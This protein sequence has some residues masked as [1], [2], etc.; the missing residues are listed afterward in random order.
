MP[1]KN[2]NTKQ[3]IYCGLSAAT[4][5]LLAVLSDITQKQDASAVEQLKSALRGIL[6]VQTYG[7]AVALVLILLAVA[8]SFIFSADSNKKAFYLGASILAIMVTAVP[9]DAKPNLDTIPNPSAA[10]AANDLGWWDRLLIPSP[11]LAQNAPP[12]TQSSP[13]TVQIE[14]ADKKL[15]SLAIFTLIDPSNGQVKRS[16]VQGSSLRFYVQNRPY[17][18]RVQVDGYTIAESSINPPLPPPQTLSITLF[19]SRVPLSIQRLLL[20]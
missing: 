14:T 13:V 3:T 10:G 6:G 17:T 15:V 19:P 11:V 2:A 12:S 16:R 1:T 8:L 9:Y 5:G 7:W 4:G 18:L 20:K